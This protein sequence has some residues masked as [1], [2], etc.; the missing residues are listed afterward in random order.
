ML[1]VLTY[2]PF[3]VAVFLVFCIL[4]SLRKT[5]KTPQ[6]IKS[7]KLGIIEK[8][9]VNLVQVVVVAH[10]VERPASTLLKAVEAN[11][12]RKV[13][14]KY[15]FL[16]SQSQGDNA[17][18]GYIK[19]FM[20][21]AEIAFAERK[22]NLNPADYVQIKRL[23]YD[24]TTVPYIFYQCVDKNSSLKRTITFRGNQKCEG[25][26]DY[27]KQVSAASVMAQA[28]LS[29]APEE[30]SKDTVFTDEIITY[31]RRIIQGLYEPISN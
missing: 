12:L 26:A 17:L 2:I 11:F 29:G 13:P 21:I 14:V 27:Y 10:T 16:I 18:N 4:A 30:I 28:I 8:D 5:R 23:S 31:P 3:V 19:M 25:V 20:V 7:D 24:W 1:E 9:L 6:F 15:L 22:D